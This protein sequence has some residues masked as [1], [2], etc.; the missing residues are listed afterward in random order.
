MFL[1][2]ILFF[3]AILLLMLFMSLRISI[4]LTAKSSGITIRLKGSIFKYI[5]IVE[6]KKRHKKQKRQKRQRK[7]T[8]KNS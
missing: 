2:V 8:G 6:V 1:P 3:V 4:E 5:K 7:K